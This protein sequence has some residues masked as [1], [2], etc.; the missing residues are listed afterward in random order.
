MDR[1]KKGE[2]VL[3]YRTAFPFEEGLS[4]KERHERAAKMER[5]FNVV[6]NLPQSTRD[7]VS[8]ERVNTDYYDKETFL[9]LRR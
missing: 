5:K 6:I 7:F 2:Y 1:L 9:Q 4:T 8:W 3:F